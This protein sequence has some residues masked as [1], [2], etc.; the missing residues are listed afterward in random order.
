M[1]RAV[2]NQMVSNDF[3]MLCWAINL[4]WTRD[5]ISVVTQ[6]KQRRQEIELTFDSTAGLLE[7][8]CL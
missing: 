4:L 5:S 1:L 8:S 3:R 6:R 2:C 7:P